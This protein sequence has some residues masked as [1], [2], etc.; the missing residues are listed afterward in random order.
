MSKIIFNQLDD[1]PSS[2]PVGAV[3]IYAKS[4]GGMYYKNASN[5]EVLITNPSAD[6]NN[7]IRT[8]SQFITEHITLS[9]EKNGLTAGPVTIASGYTVRVAASANWKIV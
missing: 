6:V 9:G 4:D 1:T 5:E 8:N 7:I 2:Q 3:M